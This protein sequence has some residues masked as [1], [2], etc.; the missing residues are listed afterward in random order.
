M[1]KINLLPVAKKKAP[2]VGKAKVPKLELKKI[3]LPIGWIVVGLIFIGVSLA[4]MALIN[5]RFQQ[6]TQQIQSDIAEMKRKIE[7]FN[8]DIVKIEE[9]KRVKG[10][11]FQK[12]EIIRSLKESQSGPV[13]MM[14]ALS[15]STPPGLW[16]SELRP[17]GEAVYNI[18][19]YAI[20]TKL[21]VDFINN[22]SKSPYFSSV[23]LIGLSQANLPNYPENIQQFVLSANIKYRG[24]EGQT[25]Q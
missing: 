12:I 24:E 19:G 18:T 11:L 13:R 4:I 9:A 1:I 23:E 15:D 16:L 17:V 8:V 6:R 2:A 25:R 22:I 7:A 21:I 10:E 3:K 5:L 14:A 20:Q